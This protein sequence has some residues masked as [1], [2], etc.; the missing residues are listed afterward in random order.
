VSSVYSLKTQN[1]WPNHRPPQT[2]TLIALADNIEMSP[3]AAQWLAEAADAAAFPPT[4]KYEADTV[5]PMQAIEFEAQLKDGVIELPE[6]YR[7]LPNLA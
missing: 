4:G 5:A 6:P 1:K 2:P 3:L 7:H